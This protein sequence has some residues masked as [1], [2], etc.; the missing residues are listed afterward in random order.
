M[1]ETGFENNI[2][3]CRL[4]SHTSHKLQPCDVGFFAPLKAAYRERAERLD[5]S[6]VGTTG[7]EHF[8]SLYSLAREKAFTKKNIIAAW[9]VCGLFPRN[10]DRVLRVTPK[11]PAQL[12]VPNADEIK[13]GSCPQD[14]VLQTPVTPVS[15]EGFTSLYN[16]I[17]QD[18]LTLNETSQQ[19]LRR[20]VQKL[21]NAGQGSFAEAALLRY[22]NQFL[23]RM[24][25]EARVRRSTKS[26]VLGKGEGK[27]MSFEDIE[28]ARAK[29]YCER[30][31]KGQGK[32]W[33]EA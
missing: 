13:V 5:R 10:P 31:H 4:P 3:L 25:N 12:T 19:R 7:K 18:A 22:Q 30:G 20:R 28:E 21:A 24:N 32:T 2:I 1:A 27:V 6:G 16:Q 15:A 14:E 17:K 33:S 8:T 26:V 23:T 11:P 29:A 9:A